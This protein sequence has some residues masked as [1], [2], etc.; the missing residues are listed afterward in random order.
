MRCFLGI[1]KTQTKKIFDVA[2]THQNAE[3]RWIIAC[4]KRILTC[5]FVDI[6]FVF[7]ISPPSGDRF[8]VAATDSIRKLRTEVLQ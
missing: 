4:W 3:H 2:I 7:L 8:S 5:T 1:R 6:S